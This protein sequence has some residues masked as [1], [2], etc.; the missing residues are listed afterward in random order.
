LQCRFAE[1]LQAQGTRCF[2]VLP[3]DFSRGITVLLLDGLCQGLVL[4]QGF[5]P[6]VSCIRFLELPVAL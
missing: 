6:A 3:G 2:H 1:K 5:S 4:V